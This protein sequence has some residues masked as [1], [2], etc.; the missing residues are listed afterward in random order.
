[1]RAPKEVLAAFLALTA[2]ERGEVVR[3][4]LEALRRGHAEEEGE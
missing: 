4:G 1:M 2:G 3:L